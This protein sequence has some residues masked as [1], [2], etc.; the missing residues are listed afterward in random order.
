MERLRILLL[1]PDAH[2]E[3][4]CGSL[5]GYSEAQ[6]L[7]RLHD[8]TIVVRF[9]HEEALRRRQ[10]S[11]HSVEAISLP[12]LERIFAWSIRRIFKNN[13][14]NQL[15]QAFAYPF[16]VVL[17]LQAWRQMRARILAGEF[18]V[19]LRLLPITA[20]RPSPFAYFLRN[21]P[22]PF[23]I[24][25]INGGLPWPQGFRQAKIQN[26]WISGLRPLYRFLPFARS[27]YRCAAAIIAGSS[28]TYAEFA[29]HCEK[30][31]FLPENGVEL[32]LC[33][34][35]VKSPEL[36]AKLELIFVGSLIPLKACD[37]ALRGAAPLLRDD[38]ARFTVVG[39]GPER[40][41]LEQLT[42]SLGIEKAVSFCGM[43]SHDETM[44]RLWSADVLVF[45]S[46]RDF[47]GGVV[48]EA[49]A[50][51]VV[52][53]VADFGGPGDT[54]RPEVGYKVALTNEAAVVSQIE[55]I[56]T[57]LAR[58]RVSLERL[59]QQGISYARKCL[60]W[61]AKAQTLTSIMRW[62]LGQGPKPKL[63]PPKMLYPECAGV[64]QPR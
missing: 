44:R 64:R 20:I 23:V 61:D 40:K 17:E 34:R 28:H 46:I 3:Y 16:S 24:G 60:S 18:D 37:L 38:L 13:Y 54:V 29:S 4:I 31:F 35:T 57:G 56:L 49:L 51:G 50:A 47:G 10:G 15:L 8:V 26:G 42:I 39:D 9:S 2:P 14:N 19:V 52:P 1:A 63:P 36:G 33:S 55:K 27:T 6:A 5:I 11:I 43:L 25:P 41:H 12:R 58:D 30:L 22:V 32:S 48:F 45:P 21:G 59:R 53:V 7:A 62:A